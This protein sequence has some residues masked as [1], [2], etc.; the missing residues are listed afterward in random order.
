MFIRLV[1]VEAA[2]SSTS[3]FL[4][5]GVTDA[6]QPPPSSDRFDEHG[7]EGIIHLISMSYV[8]ST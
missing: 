3:E 1:P 5:R 4:G 2:I 7:D 6:R 8:L